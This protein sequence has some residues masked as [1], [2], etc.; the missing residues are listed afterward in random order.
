M[1]NSLR[2]QLL[3][4]GLV[5]QDQAKAVDSEVKSKTH[6]VQK[7]KRRN[8]KQGVAEV[9]DPESAAYLA[10]KAR[11]EEIAKA[12][13]LN[14][15]RELERQQREQLVQIRQLIECYFV[16]D[17][18]A[19]SGYHFVEHRYIKTVRV[20]RDQRQQLALGQLA[21]TVLDERYHLVPANIVQK[22]Q[23][24][25][26]ELL[27][28]FHVPVPLTRHLDSGDPE[29]SPPIPDHLIW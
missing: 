25:A 24:R 13:I 26:P 16:N 7:Q 22:I 19:D 11:E 1:S 18:E 15:Q 8:Q 14:Q 20:T 29:L 23:D 28:C 27:V 17:P 10:A 5:T 9:V 6:Q 21:I 12:K 4:K 2:D 3:K